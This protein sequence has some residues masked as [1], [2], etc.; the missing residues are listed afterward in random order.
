M[1]KTIPTDCSCNGL[2]HPFH[3]LLLQLLQ[4]HICIIFD[5]LRIES[6]ESR[7]MNTKKLNI[8]FKSL[9]GWRRRKSSSLDIC[10]CRSRS[11]S[12]RAWLFIG[13]SNWRRRNRRR[14]SQHATNSCTKTAATNPGSSSG[15]NY[16]FLYDKN[17]SSECFRACTKLK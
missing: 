10:P 4:P 16:Q 14:S 5:G 1:V 8:S 17:I 6:K 11:S 15:G 12:W 9:Q 7:W 3:W 2:N 13:C